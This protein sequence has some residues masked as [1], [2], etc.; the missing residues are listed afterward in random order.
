MHY[1]AM[2]LKFQKSLSRILRY[3][4]AIFDRAAN[5]LQINIGF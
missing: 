5:G 3:C 2:L 4:T 1:L